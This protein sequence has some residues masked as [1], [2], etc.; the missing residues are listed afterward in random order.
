[1]KMWNDVN[2]TLPLEEGKYIVCTD[3]RTVFSTKFYKHGNGGH[4]GVSQRVKITHWM[5]LP[6]PPSN[7]EVDEENK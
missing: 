7:E 1:M 5:N 4:F 6:N 2:I 3:K